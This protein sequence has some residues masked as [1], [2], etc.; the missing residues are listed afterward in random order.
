MPIAFFFTGFH[1]QYHQPE[2]TVEKIDFPKLA[3]VSA[4]VYDIGFELAQ[5]D[6][7]PMVD[8]EKWTSLRRRRRGLPKAPAAPVRPEKQEPDRKKD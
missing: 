7:R 6:A 1:R 4:F 8:P 5:A 3:R 2:D